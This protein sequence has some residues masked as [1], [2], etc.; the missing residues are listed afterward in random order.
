MTGAVRQLQETSARFGLRTFAY[1][2]DHPVVAD[3]RQRHPEIMSQKRGAGYW[4]WK[5]SIILDALKSCDDGTVVL[6]TDAAM[7]MVADPS[8]MLRLALSFPAMLFELIFLVPKGPIS[9]PM[10]AWTKR[11]C[12]VLLGADTPPFYRMQ[13]LMGGIQIYRNSSEVRSFLEEVIA[14]A[15]DPRIL[16]DQP[17]TQGLENLPDFRD[18]RH[19]QAI[20]TIVAARHG[21]PHFPDPTQFGHRGPR[22]ELS[23][24]LDGVD[25]PAAPYGQIFD[26]HR[27]RDRSPLAIARAWL[28]PI[29]PGVWADCEVDLPLT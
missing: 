22:P 17:N 12:F 11:D 20:L 7:H 19:D 2:P 15:P 18:H 1:T 8:P 5:P 21:L 13:Q 29:R 26:L 4:L 23:P 10:S 28:N 16:T 6:Y 3:L 14:V 27:R 25:R 9:F 24:D